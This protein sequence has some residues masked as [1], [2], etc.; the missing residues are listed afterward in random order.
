[1]RK[2]SRVRPGKVERESVDWS[3]FS[4]VEGTG[5]PR[6]AWE[7]RMSSLILVG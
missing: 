5:E 2:E 6:V 7:K 4:T 3:D 1:M